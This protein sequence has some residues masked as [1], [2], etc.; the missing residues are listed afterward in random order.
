MLRP[1]SPVTASASHSDSQS[2]TGLIIL[3][4]GLVCVLLAWGSWVYRLSAEKPDAVLRAAGAAADTVPE[5]AASGLGFLM[6]V[7]L[8]LVLFALLGSYAI[9]RAARRYRQATDRRPP[10]PSASDD[11]WSM[12]SV[13]RVAVPC[14]SVVPSPAG[15]ALHAT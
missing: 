4:L 12:R 13:T 14:L 7:A 10:L 2:R 5:R 3:V 8:F 1:S 15:L 9:L 11:V 6:A